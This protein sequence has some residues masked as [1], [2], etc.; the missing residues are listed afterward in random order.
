MDEKQDGLAGNIR[1]VGVATL[2]VAL[3]FVA[4]RLLGLARDMIIANLFGTSPQLDAYFAAFRLPDLV[5][6]LLTGAVLGSAF[7]PTFATYLVKHSREE[8]WELA[9]SV[10]N[11]I[12]AVTFALAIILII[13][14]PWVVPLLF[15][16]FSP[17][18]QR[19]TVELS[20]IMLVSP[21]FFSVSGI[22]TGISQAH[23]RFLFPALA[24]IFYNLSIIVAALT[25]GD[26]L[27]VRGLAIGVATGSLLHLLIQ[28]PDLFRAGMVYRLVARI[29]HP[30]VREVARLMGPRVIGLA[31]SQ[32]NFLVLTIMASTLAS[33][34]IAALNYGWV[35]MMMPLGI[36]GMA[37]STALFP[38]MAQQA[39]AEGSR[40]L[41]TT[42]SSGLRLIL[43]FTIPASV[44]LIILRRPLVALIF[45]RGLFSAESTHI[46][47]Q[48]VLFYS[49]GL[50]AHASIEILVRGFYSL[51]DTKSPV[52]TAVAVMA[53]NIP[54]SLA[55]KHVMGHAG[56]ALSVSLT[57]I[58]EAGV[59][60][61]LLRRRLRTL[62]EPLLATSLSRTCLATLA[63]A[64]LLGLVRAVDG[65]TGLPPLTPAVVVLL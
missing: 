15:R 8:A 41:A 45:Q 63:M 57:T 58:T 11:I 7:I 31:A 53:M 62:D 1:R 16:T 49:I 36:F 42:T 5:F 61:F 10:L 18:S 38:T 20:R 47:S 2:L 26:H 22:I 46:T 44:G 12:A 65:Q 54:L 30:A 24:P 59:L 55:L 34:S 64:G 51:H 23:H 37:I 48:A 21:I 28:L 6:Q 27:G 3:S 13:I 25:L 40:A 33:G 52:A 17:E 32:G 9:S 4:S 29:H 14:A 56:L 35:I 39:A 19:L 43:F 50:F 60:F